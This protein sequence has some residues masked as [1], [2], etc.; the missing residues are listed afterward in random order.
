MVDIFV[1]ERA[2]K[3]IK[4]GEMKEMRQTAIVYDY[5]RSIFSAYKQSLLIFFSSVM[6]SMF[7]FAFT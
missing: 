2:K 6:L 4:D 5:V 1:R 7:L 3:E